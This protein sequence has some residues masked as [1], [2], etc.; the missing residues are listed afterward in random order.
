MAAAL[1]PRDADKQWTEQEEMGSR[2]K[3]EREPERHWKKVVLAALVGLAM[4]PLVVAAIAVFKSDRDW[5]HAKD[6][7]ALVYVPLVGVLGVVIGRS[8]PRR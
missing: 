8:F 6:Y 7:L 5:N 3:P 4:V 2:F 1:D